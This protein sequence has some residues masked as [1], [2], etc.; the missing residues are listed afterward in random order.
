MQ[1]QTCALVFHVQ[2][3]TVKD[4]KSDNAEPLPGY[5][6]TTSAKKTNTLRVSG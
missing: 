5:M 2:V 1:Y 3:V 4:V 6:I